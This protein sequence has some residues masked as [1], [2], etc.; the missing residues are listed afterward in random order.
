MKISLADFN[1]ETVIMQFPNNFNL[2]IG[3]DPR[4]GEAKI[5]EFAKG[6]ARVPKSL[7]EQLERFG[8]RP[9]DS[10]RNEATELAEKHQA[11]VPQCREASDR[12]RCLTIE[13]K[14]AQEVAINAGNAAVIAQQ[15]CVNLLASQPRPESYPTPQELEAWKL[16]VSNAR[17][18]LEKRRAVAQEASARRGGLER[19]LLDAHKQLALLSFQEK[20]LREQLARLAPSPAMSAPFAPTA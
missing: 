3:R 19:D 13:V 9:Y 5:V 7:V 14:A 8:V 12:V 15:R 20:R 18:E 11:I 6:I 16:S 10:S 4:T 1:E 17:S 2:I